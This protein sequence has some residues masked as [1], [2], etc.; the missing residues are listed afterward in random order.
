MPAG[1]LLPPPSQADAALALESA[2]HL[3]HR[4]ERE[5]RSLKLVVDNQGEGV[6][7][8]APLF[9]LILE[10]LAQMARGNAITLV[11]VHAELT[12]QQA[13]DLLGVSRPFLIKLLERGELPHRKVGRHRRV[14]FMDLVEYRKRI[15]ARRQESLDELVRLSK[16]LGLYD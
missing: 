9:Q 4:S 3:E 10:V 13:A 14:R 7:L 6:L 12:T 11:P 5:V 15:G 1:T 2:R 8:P 16:D